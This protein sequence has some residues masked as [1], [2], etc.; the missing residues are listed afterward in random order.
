[1]FFSKA[2]SS[3]SLEYPE[4][5]LGKP[6]EICTETFLKIGLFTTE[7]ECIN[8]LKYMS[9][10]FFKAILFFGRSGMNM[11]QQNFELIPLVDFSKEYDDEMLYKHFGINEAEIKFIDSLF[12]ENKTYDDM[13]GGNE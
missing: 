11:S 4:I 3:N 2:Y 1:M 5:I 8:C 13:D 10:R 12:D 9:T 6:N 7:N